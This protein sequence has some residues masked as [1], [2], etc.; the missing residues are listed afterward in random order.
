M[1]AVFEAAVNLIRDEYTMKLGTFA[2]PHE[3]IAVIREEYLEL[4]HEVF[5]GGEAEA[6]TEAVQL[7]AMAIRF[8]VDSC[9]VSSDG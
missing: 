4:E 3:G 9:G 8:L 6:A 2:S 7:A 5:H 1:T